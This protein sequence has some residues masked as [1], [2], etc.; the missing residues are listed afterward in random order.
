MQPVG[1]NR[2]ITPR[3]VTQPTADAGAQLR[4]VMVKSRSCAIVE[5]EPNPLLWTLATATTRLGGFVSCV[6][7]CQR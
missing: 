6:N 2:Y 1:C 5:G 7:R 3:W 4:C